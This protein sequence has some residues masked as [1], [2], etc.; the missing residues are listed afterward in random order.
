MRTMGERIVQSV[1]QAADL[2]RGKT[3]RDNC[4]AKPDSFEDASR[5]QVKR[6]DSKSS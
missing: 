1:E 6:E 3:L 5:C 2:F 4:S